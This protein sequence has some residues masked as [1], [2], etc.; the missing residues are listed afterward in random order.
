MVKV[1]LAKMAKTNDKSGGNS[2]CKTTSNNVDTAKKTTAHRSFS[3]SNMLSS[4]CQ[5]CGFTID[6]NTKALQCEKCDKN[7]AWIY[8]DCFGMAED[9]YDSLESSS[10]SMQLHWFCHE[11]EIKV[12][13]KCNNQTLA[14]I[15]EVIC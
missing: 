13:E 4:S 1:K 11:C 6:E 2:E 14:V 12:F 7:C 8:F 3:A 5:K 9:W 10:M 15:C